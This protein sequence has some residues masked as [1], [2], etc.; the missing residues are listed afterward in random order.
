MVDCCLSSKWCQH[1]ILGHDSRQLPQK[2]IK[3]SQMRQR[4]WTDTVKTNSEEL[5]RKK[6]N[7]ATTGSSSM[8]RQGKQHRVDRALGFFSSRP[9]WVSPTPSS[10]GERVTPP[11]FGG[12]GG[13]WY[14]HSLAREGVWGSQCGRGDRH[15]VTLGIYVL[16]GQTKLSMK[17]NGVHISVEN[18]L[19]W[20]AHTQLLQG[21]DEV[22]EL[23]NID[24]CEYIWERG[25]G[26][27]QTPS[28]VP[29]HHHNRSR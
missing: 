21:R 27:A 8:V 28:Q 22:E 11:H 4:R 26:F 17:S 9:N 2:P 15:C 7:S 6:N 14:T 12:G 16:Y 19:G 13:G 3:Y 23:C 20:R 24:S 29:Q 18:L 5:S 1:W 25:V 10:A